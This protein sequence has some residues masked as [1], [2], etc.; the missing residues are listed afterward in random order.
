MKNSM[1]D[2]EVMYDA[3]LKKDTRF[4]GIFFV[5]VKTTG[6]FCRPGCTAKKPKKENVEFFSTAADAIFCGYRPCRLCNPLGYQGEIP[7]WIQSLLDELKKNPEMFMKDSYL[8]DRGIEPSR[9]RRWFK[10]NLGMTF[11]AYLR[12]LRM[13]RAFGRIRYGEKVI[14]TAFESGYES[15]SGFTCSFQK[16]T[17]FSP[18]RSR[19]NQVVTITRILSP[20]GPLIAG[21]TR[22]GLCLLEFAD[23]RMLETQLARLKKM[24]KSELIPGSNSFFKPLNEQLNEYFA[25][26]RKEFDIPLVLIGTPFQKKIWT[27]LQGIPYGST[28]SYKEQA[29]ILGDPKAIRAVA[30]ANGD[31][32]ISI[33]IP[34]HRVIGSG[35]E[36]VGY[37]GGLWRKKFLLNLESTNR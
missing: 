13:G 25:G 21:A 7:D 35:G 19:T 29:E 8:R 17:G 36:L 20:L 34:C 2:R 12:A 10:K 31:N 4:E 32:R 22:E 9:I 15:L 14:E 28:R 1:P 23:R 6:I 37:G 33:I 16:A 30:R 18:V 11:Q 3:L 24:L 26:K 5:G 27:I